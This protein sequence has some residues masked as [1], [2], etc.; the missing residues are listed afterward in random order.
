[1]Q[2]IDLHLCLTA[3]SHALMA[4]TTDFRAVSDGTAITVANRFGP[5]VHCLAVGA[6]HGSVLGHDRCS[7][8]VISVEDNANAL[9]ILIAIYLENMTKC[10]N[11]CD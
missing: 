7:L 5:V 3:V 9:L 6:S 2:S 1:M 11:A 4:F 10:L 8:A